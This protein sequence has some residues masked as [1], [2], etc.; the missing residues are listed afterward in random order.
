MPS[1]LTCLVPKHTHTQIPSQDPSGLSWRTRLKPFRVAT[2]WDRQLPR[3]RAGRPVWG[4][5]GTGLRFQGPHILDSPLR[6]SAIVC[7]AR[8][9]EEGG[10]GSR[11]HWFGL[12]L[13]VFILFGADLCRILPSIS[14]CTL[15][16][17]VL[18]R[19]FA[20]M[21]EFGTLQRNNQQLPAR[22]SFPCTTGGFSPSPSST[23]R[24]K[25]TNDS[26]SSRI[27]STS[28]HGRRPL[29]D[30]PS[31]RLR[32]RDGYAD[33]TSPSAQGP[34]TRAHSAALLP[35]LST[36]RELALPAAG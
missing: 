26:S 31:R 32:G 25:H 14:T 35:P 34:P 20:R 29:S 27:P 13:L 1:K 11:C 28:P 24:Q 7:R 3:R 6:S 30:G 21:N 8:G 33:Q 18:D 19:G 4:H 15:V 36:S 17:V 23:P 22:N 12:L 5:R 2:P 9:G 10:G 16:G